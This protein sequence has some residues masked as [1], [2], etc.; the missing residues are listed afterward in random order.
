MSKKSNPLLVS[1][2]FG[3]FSIRNS[4]ETLPIPLEI[5]RGYPHPW[6]LNFRIMPR[7]G[8]DRFFPDYFQF[9]SPVN[10]DKDITDADSVVKYTINVMDILR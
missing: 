7:L 10:F 2:R 1:Q 3:R 9:P 6:Q 4:A 8:H 5:F